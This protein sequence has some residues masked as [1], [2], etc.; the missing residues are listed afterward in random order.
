[1]TIRPIKNEVDYRAALA[2]I[3][4]LMGTI[5]PNTPDGDRFDLL[6][7]LVE[8]YEDAHYPM[9]EQSDPITLLEFVMEQQGLTRKDL[10][11]YLGP[12]QRVWDIMERRRPLSLAMIRRLEKGL[13]IPATLLIQEYPLY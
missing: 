8:R 7:D 2:E 9:G 10:E 12:R 11:P 1:M 3:E 6:V 4:E 13:H 5:E